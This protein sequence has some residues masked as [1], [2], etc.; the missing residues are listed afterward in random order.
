MYAIVL[1]LDVDILSKIYNGENYENA[2]LDIMNVLAEFGFTMH[3][4]TVYFGNVEKVDAVICVLA[5]ME[6]SKK[7]P[8]FS[9]SV[10]YIRMIRIE[11]VEDLM[12]AVRKGTLG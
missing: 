4:G 12:P 9:P 1:S 10:K 7:Y 8:W 2:Y 6:L 5:A 3:Q 11:D